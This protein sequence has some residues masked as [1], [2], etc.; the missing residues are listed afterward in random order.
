M[1]GVYGIKNERNFS[2]YPGSRKQSVVWQKDGIVYL[3]GGFGF[4]KSGSVGYLNDLWKY[5]SLTNTWTWI[6]GNDYINSVDNLTHI[7]A[8]CCSGSWVDGDDLYLS[9]GFGTYN[10]SKTIK[11]RNDVWLYSLVKQE[12]YFVQGNTNFNSPTNEFI[13]R[14]GALIWVN[15]VTN[16]V[17]LYGGYNSELKRYFSD[18]WY[19]NRTQTRWIRKSSIKYNVYSQF[20]SDRNL[21][22]SK[23]L[24]S[25]RCCSVTWIDRNGYM[26]LYG[27]YGI[28]DEKGSVDFLNDVWAMDVDENGNI[29]WIYVK[30]NDNKREPIYGS[31]NTT[32]AF[33]WPGSRAYANYWYNNKSSTLWLFGSIGRGLNTSPWIYYQDLWS[34]EPPVFVTLYDD[35][36]EQKHEIL[37]PIII[38]IIGLEVLILLSLAIL[39]VYRSNL[40]RKKKAFMEDINEKINNTA[41]TYDKDNS[42]KESNSGESSI[43]P[44]NMVTL[45]DWAIKKRELKFGQV[46]GHGSSG[47]I[48]KG[49]WRHQNVAIKKLTEERLIGER[50]GALKEVQMVMNLRP[51]LNVIR[52]LGVCVTESEIFIVMNLMHTS[53]DKLLY[54]SKEPLSKKDI[55]TIIQGIVAGMIHLENE[56]ICHRD[57]ASRNICLDKD[58]VPAITDFGMSR[59]IISSKAGETITQMGPVAWMAPEC[60][61]QIYSSKSDVW[62]FGCVLYEILMRKKPHSECNDLFELA[63]M[64]RDEGKI[65]T[66]EP[67]NYD[68]TLIKLMKKCWRYNPE[69]RPTFKK[70]G[71]IIERKIREE[72]LNNSIYMQ[73]TIININNNSNKNEPK[74]MN[75]NNNNNNNMDIREEYVDGFY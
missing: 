59:K 16:E 17:W 8:R 50:E 60:F 66:I 41:H 19:W 27:G 75:N 26:L 31:I 30:E 36:E 52:I 70:I 33:I 15:P 23:N 45:F 65:P 40:R 34:Y 10:D 49:K 68:Q 57:L 47:I 20:E 9:F 13:E 7:G 22:S 53:L 42:D 38:S 18:T 25:S 62:S 58:K 51:H 2:N 44:K 35:E 3:F 63:I 43:T 39:V 1:H 67:G 48:Y 61:K 21:P 46:I 5:D 69:E 14:S 28:V 55:Y 71:K 56:K 12:W 72:E 73:Q 4:A 32:D 11:E 64:I 74:D 54:E 6:N 29:E 24:P 37:I